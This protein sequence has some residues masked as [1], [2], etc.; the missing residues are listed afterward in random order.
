MEEKMNS[1][2]V[3]GFDEAIMIYKHPDDVF[4]S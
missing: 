4:Q 2:F 3:T 1:A